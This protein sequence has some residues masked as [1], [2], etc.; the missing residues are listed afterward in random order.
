LSPARATKP[1]PYPK[2]EPQAI[3]PHFTPANRRSKQELL[4]KHDNE[5]ILTFN[6]ELG[7]PRV[8]ADGVVADD[9]KGES[10]DGDE[11]RESTLEDLVELLDIGVEAEQYKET[12]QP[13]KLKS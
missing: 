10:V 4:Q 12:T 5:L 2:L 8:V 13:T 3:L 7:E 11:S 1:L 9:G 6:A